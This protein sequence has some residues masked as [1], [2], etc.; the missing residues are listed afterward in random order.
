MIKLDFKNL[1]FKI[2]FTLIEL[3]IAI[4]LTASIITLA[5]TFLFFSNRTFTKGM[6]QIDIQKKLRNVINKIANELKCAKEIIKIDKDYLEFKKFVDERE[7]QQHINLS[8]D[9]LSKHIKYELK[10]KT[11]KNIDEFIM[12]V[13]N[14]E[15]VIMQFEEIN[16]D[17]FLAYTFDLNDN[18]IIFDSKINDSIQRSKI[19]LIK[20]SFKVKHNKSQVNLE[21]YV[22]PRYLY[23]YKIQPY[24]NLNK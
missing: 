9:T 17:I 4:S 19:S 3:L 20:I 24:W 14:N 18:F 7:E 5:Y 13:D 21:A 22:N 11:S 15:S 2:A 1:K 6:D 12:T 16:S 10:K 8:G 23:G